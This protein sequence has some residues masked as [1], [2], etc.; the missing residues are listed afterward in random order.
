MCVS[1]CMLCSKHKHTGGFSSHMMCTKHAIFIFHLCRVDHWINGVLCG[2][3]RLIACMIATFVIPISL[4]DFQLTRLLLLFSAPCPS[5]LLC[6]HLSTGFVRITPLP[7]SIISTS[8]LLY[9][10]NSSS[11]V[12]VNGWITSQ[13]AHV[14]IVR[15]VNADHC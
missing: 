2:V 3:W 1:I 7:Y 12:Q 14:S 11:I 15:K 9:I 6:H 10:V 4:A 8:S 5:S 13:L